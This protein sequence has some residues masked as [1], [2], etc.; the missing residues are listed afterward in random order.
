M[1]VFFLL[2]LRPETQTW[3]HGPSEARA[4]AW[5]TFDLVDDTNMLM[6]EGKR[7]IP[8]A[9]MIIIHLPLVTC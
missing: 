7:G 1:R 6:D 3:G 4:A 8:I 5:H 9:A 2:R